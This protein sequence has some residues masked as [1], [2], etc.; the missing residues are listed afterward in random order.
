M[1]AIVGKLNEI[2]SQQTLDY[3]RLG[4]SS[5]VEPKEGCL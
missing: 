5:T 4:G 2:S 3:L 1:T